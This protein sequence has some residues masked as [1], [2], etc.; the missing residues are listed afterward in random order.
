M[1]LCYHLIT[2]TVELL[3]C[4]THL[5]SPDS[6]DLLWPEVEIKSLNKNVFSKWRLIV[7]ALEVE[8]GG[9]R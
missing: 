6:P 5:R 4:H 8:M 3:K 9:V 7:L 2:S 1:T